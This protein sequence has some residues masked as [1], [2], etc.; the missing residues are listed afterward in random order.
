MLKVDDTVFILVDVQGKLAQLM[1][2]KES[3]FKNLQILVKAMQVMDIPVVWVEQ[4]PEKMG[5]TIPELTTLLDGQTSVP[6]SSFSCW[7]E[8]KFREK[9][10]TINRPNILM[11]GIETHVCIYQTARDLLNEG[12]HVEVVADAVSSRTLPNIKIGMDRI[13]ACGADITSTE[14]VLLELL[15]SANNPLFKDVLACILGR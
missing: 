14:M 10:A 2:Q 3:L 15:G 1:Y 11:A 8:P 4:V 9:L 5:P 12:R 13:K 7:G 6:K